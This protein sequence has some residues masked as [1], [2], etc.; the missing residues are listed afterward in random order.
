VTGNPANSLRRDLPSTATTCAL[1]PCPSHNTCLF[2]AATTRSNGFVVL[3][4]LLLLLLL[5]SL[6]RV[7]LYD[8]LTHKRRFIFEHDLFYTCLYYN[9]NDEYFGTSSFRYK[10]NLSIDFFLGLNSIITRSIFHEIV[11]AHN[12][13]DD[14][15]LFF[16]YELH[17]IIHNTLLAAGHP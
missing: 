14:L 10:Q 2:V 3:L 16:S 9:I 6:F 5:W 1:T 8:T 11:H 15:R 13:D 12:C 17:N 4:L 7:I